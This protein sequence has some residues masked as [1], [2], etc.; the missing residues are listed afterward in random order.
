[1]IVANK[2]ER[3]TLREGGK[4]LGAILD[5]VARKCAPGVSLLELDAY[6][7]EL[8]EERNVKPSFLG[9]HD[10]PAALCISVN[11]GVV[12]GI[13]D[14]YTLRNGD[15]LTLDGGVWHDG[16]CTD[17]AIT[18]GVGNISQENQNLINAAYEAREAQIEAAVAGNTIGDIG[19]A[20][21]RVARKYGYDYPEELGGHGVGKEVHES[22][23]VPTYGKAG[24][25]EILKEGMV[26]ALEPILVNG[27]GRVKLANDGW[28]Y[29]TMDGS[30]AAQFEHTVIVG[31]DKAE[32][33]TE[34]IH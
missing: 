18:V 27:S 2:Q 24:K 19:A 16:L 1:M 28:L 14:D 21:Q 34:A 15:I 33:L 13:P 3:E 23:F 12:H 7:R 25:G 20:S 11:Q 26:L 8:M 22:P 31:K 29:E 9:F 17:S 32:V 5:K 4:I 30:R 10:F 6:A